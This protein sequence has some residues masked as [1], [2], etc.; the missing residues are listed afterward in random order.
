ML[1]RGR[2]V[3]IVGRISMDQSIVDVSGVSEVSLGDEVVLLG[4]Q[5]GGEISAEEIA[6]WC[7]TIPYETLC[8]VGARV[9]RRAAAWKESG[10]LWA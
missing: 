8:G 3:P 6:A 9:T 7:G 10:Y 1:V 2:R 4:R 5:G